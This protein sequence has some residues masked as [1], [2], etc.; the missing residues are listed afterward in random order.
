VKLTPEKRDRS[1]LGGK[2]QTLTSADIRRWKQQKDAVVSC[3]SIGFQLELSNLKSPLPTWEYLVIG[4]NCYIGFNMGFT[5]DL[6]KL[7]ERVASRLHVVVGEEN[8]KAAFISPFLGILGYDTTDPTEVIHEYFAD[9]ATPGKV[10][11]KKVD[12]AIAINSKIVMLV[13]AK[14]CT[15]KPEVHDGQLK[16]Y[17][18]AVRTARISIVTN[19]VEYLFFTDLEDSNMMDKEPFF[20][21]NILDYGSKEIENLKLFHR[22][23][24]DPTKI[25]NDAEEIL[26]SQ[27]ISGLVDSILVSPS[28]KFVHFLIKEMGTVA[29]KYEFRGVVTANIIKKFHPIV[30]RSLQASLVSL[31]TRSVNQEMTHPESST[32]SPPEVDE[33]EIELE[34]E[35]KNNIVTT[36]EELS[37][38][39]KIQAIAKTST[40]FKLEPQSKDTVSYFGINLGKSTWW[41]MRLYL[42]SAKKS[43]IARINPEEAKTLAPNFTIQEVPGVNGEILS[44]VAIGSIEDLD[45]LKPLIV[46]CYELEAAKH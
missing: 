10:K 42:S 40:K 26:Y 11:P 2:T 5:E 9:F 12:Y 23:N 18:N 20:T 6:G 29:S 43:L 36:E 30:K 33:L 1:A 22:D 34:I 44:K 38:F 21:F 8:T 35:E 14:A 45:K 4:Q 41:F 7:S 31:I 15:E 32:V 27:G 13:E 37:A 28:D 46:K 3:V 25:K 16:F 17:F 39:A 19:G 24:F